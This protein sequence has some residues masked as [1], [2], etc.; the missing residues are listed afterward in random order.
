MWHYQSD[1][2]TFFNSF[3]IKII[4]VNKLY[5]LGLEKGLYD[6]LSAVV[7]TMVFLRDF[8]VYIIRNKR[9]DKLGRTPNAGFNSIA[10][11]TI[12]WKM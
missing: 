7:K 8:K 1:V 11:L 6:V 10:W 9:L 2:L 3:L 5:D 4:G 12:L